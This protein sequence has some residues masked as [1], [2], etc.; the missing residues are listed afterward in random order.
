[1]VVVGAVLG[2][3]PILNLEQVG[4]SLNEHLPASKQSLLE[5]NIQVLQRGFAAARDAVVV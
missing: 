1:M 4:Q 5:A 3:R 2:A